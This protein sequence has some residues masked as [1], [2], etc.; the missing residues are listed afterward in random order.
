LLFRGANQHFQSAARDLRVN[1]KTV[2]ARVLASKMVRFDWQKTHYR[3]EVC[4]VY[5]KI[6]A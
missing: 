5:S 1:H 3:H 4:R 6:K 2:V